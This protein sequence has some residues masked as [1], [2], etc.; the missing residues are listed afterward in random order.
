M[1]VRAAHPRVGGL[2]LALTDE[3]Q[4]TKA[5]AQGAEGERLLGAR[6]DDLAAEGSIV[7]H[8]RRI[9][10]TRAN[11]DHLVVASSGV[12]VI[13]AKRYRAEVRQVDVGGWRRRDDRLYVGRRDCTALI[14]GMDVQVAAVRAALAAAE[15]APAISAVICFL[16]AEWPLFPKP[17]RFG[18][19]TVTWSK[20]LLQQSR[21]AGPLTPEAIEAYG[22]RLDRALR[23][24]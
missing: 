14:A 24:A 7:L 9:P 18:D 10:G 15:A 13:D 20:A 23:T 22:R 3:P 11:I 17:L 12:W 5:W 16:G 6:L 2:I 21:Q 19:V 1:R 8:D 4:S